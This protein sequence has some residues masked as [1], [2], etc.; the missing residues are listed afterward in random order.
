MLPEELGVGADD[1]FHH[2]DPRLVPEI[3]D[4]LEYLMEHHPGV[5][6]AVGDVDRTL[7]WDSMER[8]PLANLATA[9]TMAE[10][11]EALRA[12]L[13]EAAAHKTV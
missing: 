1:I 6:A 8:T 11:E 3:T 4:V 13:Q 9:E 10:G 2:V 12:A 7:I 5:I